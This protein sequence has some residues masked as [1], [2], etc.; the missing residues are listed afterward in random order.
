MLLWHLEINMCALLWWAH[1]SS[2]G[3]LPPIVWWHLWP[4]QFLEYHA[5]TCNMVLNILMRSL[6]CLQSYKWRTT[7]LVV[8]RSC[9][10][11][12]YCACFGSERT[13]SL[14]RHETNHFKCILFT[15]GVLWMYVLGNGS[16]LYQTLTKQEG[17]SS[18]CYIVWYC[19]Y[20][21]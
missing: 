2:P 15:N 7:R 16:L 21:F 19:R 9:L 17:C 1:H 11:Q 4:N 8:V 20:Y 12:G 3:E 5:E 10:L 13:K 6:G 14:L 18:S